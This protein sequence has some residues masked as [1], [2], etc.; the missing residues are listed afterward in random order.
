MTAA[1]GCRHLPTS[2]YGGGRL[3]SATQVGVRVRH[4]LA[5]G[6][7]YVVPRPDGRIL[8]GSTEEEAGFDARPTP[9]GVQGLLD[10]GFRLVPDLAKCSFERAWAGLRP[11]NADG[12]P[13]LGQAPEL[14]NLYVATGHFR[15][16]LQ[17][18]AGTALVM[19]QLIL[20]EPTSVPLEIFRVDRG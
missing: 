7:R 4:V 5:E 2:P 18:S 10:F 3:A 14:E 6:A 19:A 16:G 13:Y 15:S 11:G 12:L 9:Q 8:I 1:T 17:L 20:G